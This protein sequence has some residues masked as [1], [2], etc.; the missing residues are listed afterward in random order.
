MTIMSHREANRGLKRRLHSLLGA[1]YRLLTTAVVLVVAMIT[2]DQVQA[3]AAALSAYTQQSVI[4]AALR[5]TVPPELALAVA[6]VGGVRQSHA[7][8]GQA[9]VGIMGVR[10]SLARAELGVGP[11]QL[12]VPRA[13]AGMGVALLER[14]LARHGERWELALSHYR[15]GPP[16]RCGD[17]VMVHAH[18]IDYVVDVM[19]WW[20]RYQDDETVS[21]LIG[22]VR[23]GRIQPHRFTVDDNTFLRA[24]RESPGYDVRRSP[25]GSA[26][27]DRSQGNPA[28]VTGSTGRFR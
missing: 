19:E 16:R 3:N 17:E 2:S 8:D 9:T 21:A 5:T 28:A 15:G 13:N 25:S 26:Y 20:R 6:R 27:F 23:Q 22:N 24:W 1:T 4:A 7:E 14:L 18:T 11:H 10:T 12:R